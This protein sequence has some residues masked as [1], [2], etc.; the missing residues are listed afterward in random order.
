MK[1]VPTEQVYPFYSL[2]WDIEIFFKAM[3]SLLKLQ[4]GFQGRS[5]DLLISHTTIVFVRYVEL[6]W[7]NRCNTDNHMIG[8]FF[9]AVCDEVNELEW[10]V[11][12]QQ[13]IELL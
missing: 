9:Y 1:V 13:L 10:A 12:L 2:C 8:G 5:D 3:K 7:Q 11:A 4:K 6:S